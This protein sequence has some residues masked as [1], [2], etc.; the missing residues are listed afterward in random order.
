LALPLIDIDWF[1]QVNDTY[2]HPVGDAALR[3]VCEQLRMTLRESDVLARIGGEEF[4]V[5]HQDTSADATM[6]LAE[7]LR[8]AVARAPLT[9]GTLQLPMSISVGLAI[10]QLRVSVEQ[11]LTRA[12]VALYRAKHGGRN[13]VDADLPSVDLADQTDRPSIILEAQ[14]AR[15]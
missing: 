10:F 6:G 9:V 11:L 5:I 1:K 3:A 13:R 2:G 4:M 7:W 14:T 12:D 8:L 15:G